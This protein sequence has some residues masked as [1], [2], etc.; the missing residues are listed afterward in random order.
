M[1]EKKKKVLTFIS[2]MEIL[3]HMEK[4]SLLEAMLPMFYRK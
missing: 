4:G 2:D 1:E 3:L